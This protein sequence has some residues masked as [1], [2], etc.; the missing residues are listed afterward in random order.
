M[1]TILGAYVVVVA[2]GSG[3]SCGFVEQTV[4]AVF[5]ENPNNVYR[6]SGVTILRRLWTDKPRHWGS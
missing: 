3:L 1:K 4:V 5:N 6:S 2:I